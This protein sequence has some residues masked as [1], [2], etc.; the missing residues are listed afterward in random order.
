MNKKRIG[1]TYQR[2]RMRSYIYKCISI[3]YINGYIEKKQ[4]NNIKYVEFFL[5]FLFLVTTTPK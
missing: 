1:E 4:E 2:F 3:F 5:H